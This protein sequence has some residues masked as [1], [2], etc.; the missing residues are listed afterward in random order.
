ML[1]RNEILS[2]ILSADSDEEA[3]DAIYRELKDSEDAVAAE[4]AWRS[5]LG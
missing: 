1:D 2:L 5:W 4:E 3:A